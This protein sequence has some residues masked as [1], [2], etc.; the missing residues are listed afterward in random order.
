MESAVEVAEWRDR[1]RKKGEETRGGNERKR[2]ETRGNE[3]K[4][5][6]TRGERRDDQRLKQ[7]NQLSPQ[8]HIRPPEPR[9]TSFLS[10]AA[11]EIR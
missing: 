5:E 3:R 10:H 7:K 2:E 9:L 8:P 6:E 1:P 4:R 11:V